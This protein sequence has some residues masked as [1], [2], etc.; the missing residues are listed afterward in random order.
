MDEFASLE[1]DACQTLEEVRAGIDEADRKLVDILARRHAYAVQAARMKT[2][3]SAVR[4]RPRVAQ[5]ISNAVARATDKGLPQDL[6]APIWVT[7]LDAFDAHALAIFDADRTA[8]A[9]GGR[10][11]RGAPCRL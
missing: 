10:R 9:L 8:R 1:P 5:T 3:W 7:M 11:K 2:E 4:D 6:V